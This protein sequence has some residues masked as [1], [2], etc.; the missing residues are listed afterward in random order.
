MSATP[1]TAGGQPFIKRFSRPLSAAGAIFTC[2]C[3][4]VPLV[5]L[6]SGTSLGA[7]LYQHLSKLMLGMGA[8]FLLSVWLLWQTR[9]SR[10]TGVECKSCTTSDAG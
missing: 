4:A 2:P 6:L 9:D 8:L 5:L 1:S 10:N 7:F 3:H